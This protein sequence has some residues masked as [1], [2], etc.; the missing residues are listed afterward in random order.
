MLRILQSRD[1][2]RAARADLARRRASALDGKLPRFLMRLGLVSR[3]PVGDLVKSWDLR[4][5]IDFLEETYGPAARVLDMGC[6]SCEL[7]PALARLGYGRLTGMDLN[8]R[9]IN[10]PSS[11]SVRYLAGDFLDTGLPDASFDCI[12]AIS[13]I[14][15]GFQPDRLLSEISRLL[16][17]GGAFVASFDYWPEKLSTDG[18]RLFGMSWSIF[19]E[20]EID[21]FIGQARSLGFEPHSNLEFSASAAPIHYAGYRYTFGWLVL[22]KR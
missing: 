3:A 16:V 6:F 10:M 19:S 7:L 21:A 4:R 18:I 8:P 20:E 2:I 14:E 5:T 17:P 22:R 15:H 12:T 11:R 13:V 9:V 1:E